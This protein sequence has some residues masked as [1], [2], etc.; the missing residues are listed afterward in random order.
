M[1]LFAQVYL[2]VMCSHVI[3][4]SRS[5]IPRSIIDVRWILAL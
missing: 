1:E 2:F 3:R 5:E 4:I